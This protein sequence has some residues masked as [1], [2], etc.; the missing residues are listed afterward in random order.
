MADHADIGLRDPQNRRPPRPSARRRH[1][2]ACTILERL[3]TAGQ[4]PAIEPGH[5]RLV[6]HKARPNSASTAL[7]CDRLKTGCRS[8]QAKHPPVSS[9]VESARVDLESRG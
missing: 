7:I 1:D 5:R 2:R 3:D 6:W 9:Y 8:T 4:Q